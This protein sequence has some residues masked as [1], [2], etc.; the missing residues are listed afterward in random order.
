[1]ENRLLVQ[2]YAKDGIAF[3]VVDCKIFK[4]QDEIHEN[5][6]KIQKN[7]I[8]LFRQQ[9]EKSRGVANRQRHP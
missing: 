8:S 9:P 7:N 2:N 1:M 4:L 3:G 6:K 5:T